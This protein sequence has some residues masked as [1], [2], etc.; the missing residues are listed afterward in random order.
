MSQPRHVSGVEV[1]RSCM[2][3]WIVGGMCFVPLAKAQQI[4]S[5]TPPT[6]G[7]KDTDAFYQPDQVQVIHLQVRDSDLDMMKSAVPRRIYVP[8]TFQWGSL[9]VDDVGVRYK[10]NSSSIP[11]QQHKRGFLI[12]FNEFKKGRSF[13]GLHRVALDNGVQFG[14]LFS[15]PLITSI[16]RDLGITAPRCNFAKLYVNGKYE[17]IY[18]N[19]ERIDNVFVQQHFADG[20]GALY[21]V[22]EGGAGADWTPFSQAPEA[23]AHSKLAFEP[24]S[25]A[26]R[27]DARDVLELLAQVNQTPAEEFASV[28]ET[29]IDM[30]ALLQTMAVM[31]FA[32]AF[33]QLTGW[34]PH[35]YCLYNEPQSNRW[36][37]L[38]FDLDVGFADNAFGQIPVISEWN[39]AWPI[40]GGPRRPLIEHIVDDPQLLARYRQWA[41]TILEKQFHPDVLLPRID[42]LYDRI[43]GD[44]ASDPFPHRRA[45]NPEDRDYESIVA[46][47]KDFVRHRY[48]T[49]RAQL[50]N[51][52]LRPEIVRNSPRPEQG[53]QPGPPSADAPSELHV[54][55]CSTASVTLQWTD[56]ARGEVAYVVQRAVGEQDQEFGN[57][58]GQPGDAVTEATDNRVTPGQT[59]RYRVYAVRPTPTGPQGTGV[60]NTIVVRVPAR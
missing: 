35:N 41:D 22:D 59:Y 33:D 18:V 45:T 46:S 8:A 54:T 52:G 20:N 51:P 24:K 6:T 32:G 48:A 15:E 11:G 36:H 23:L 39:A 17:G 3:V 53:P 40:P 28:M 30:D 13:L 38:P 37:Y 31:L 5:M 43:K 42:A 47:M 57:Y 7:W 4:P 44:L 29:T 19:V 12:K 10:G 58:I 16:L 50:D 25:K 49:A 55:T 56:N 34:N 1:C 26:A 21:K 27:R 60:S 9:T 2:L 14:S